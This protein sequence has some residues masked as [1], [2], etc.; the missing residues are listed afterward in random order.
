METKI[1]KTKNQKK[2]EK[3]INTGKADCIRVLMVCGRL[4]I[5]GAEKIAYEIGMHCDSARIRIDYL[6]F[7]DEIGEYEAPLR[8][9]G[10]R[11]IRMPLPAA[12]YGRFMVTL[13]KLMKQNRYQVVHS[14]TMFNSGLV[15]AVARQM[16]I[17][18]RISHAHTISSMRRTGARQVYEKIMRRLIVSCATDLVAC[19]QAAGS[20]LYGEKTFRRRGRLIMN[21]V[22]VRNFRYDPEKRKQIREQY[23]LEG[24]FI[25]GHVG[26]MAP[27]KNQIFLIELLSGILQNRPDAVLLLVGD[28]EQREML[29][30]QVEKKGLSE[31]VIMTGIRLNVQDYLDAMDVFV[32]PSIFEGMPLSV[33]EIQSN[34]LPCVLSQAVPKDVYQTDLISTASLDDPPEKWISLILEAARNHPDQYNDQM[35][36]SGFDIQDMVKKI[37]EI[38]ERVE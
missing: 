26:R 31:N 37:Y 15:M 32:L 27:E 10:H 2:A 3:Y 28:G 24:C 21:G 23:G 13:R 38:Y 16:K 8:K 36:Q 30:A 4:Q 17:P 25:I 9:K 7:F 29:T 22:D 35:L 20:W 33:L 5:G 14:H 11:V 1:L 12:G 34:G 18:V 6:I 19:G